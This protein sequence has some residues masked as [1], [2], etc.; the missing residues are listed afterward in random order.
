MSVGPGASPGAD[1]D[2]SALADRTIESVQLPRPSPP[3]ASVCV[4]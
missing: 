4:F 3:R 1:R 2:P